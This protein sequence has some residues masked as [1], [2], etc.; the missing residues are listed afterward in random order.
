ML[1]KSES[2]KYWVLLAVLLIAGAFIN[3]FEQIGEAKV[4]RRELREFP[5]QLGDWRQSGADEHFSAETEAVLRADDYVMRNYASGSTEANF[6]IGYYHSQKTGA[7]YHSPLNC[8]PG[9]GW[10]LSEPR[11]VDISTADGRSFQANA[12]I[13]QAD[14]YKEVLIYWY[15]GRGRAVAS[16]FQDKLFTIWDSVAQRRSDGAM[17]RVMTPVNDSEDK[18]MASA[19]DLAAKASESISQYVPE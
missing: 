2:L 5:A 12:Y 16:E 4:P 17:V 7:T 1:N 13:I 15:Q 10:T 18:A 14:K 19:V 3:F 6:Y 9:S 11:I 8:L